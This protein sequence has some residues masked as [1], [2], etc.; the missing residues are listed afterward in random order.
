MVYR[1]TNLDGGF[2][3]LALVASERPVHMVHIKVFTLKVLDSLLACL[4]HLLWGVVRVVQFSSNP[5]IFPADF[6]LF[7]YFREGFANP[8]LVSIVA[9][10]VKMSAYTMGNRASKSL[11]TCRA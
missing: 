2:Y 3:S 6:P 9:G 10:A 5:Y 4:P 8:F 1:Q 7:Q 11:S